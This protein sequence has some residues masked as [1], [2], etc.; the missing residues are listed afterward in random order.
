MFTGTHQGIQEEVLALKNIDRH[1]FEP[2]VAQIEA[3]KSSHFATFKDGL[4][5]LGQVVVGQVE[6]EPDEPDEG[7]ALE[8]G[9]R[10][11]A[12]VDLLKLG[13]VL[14]P[15]L[16]DLGHLVVAQTELSKLGQV[17]EVAVVDRLDQVR[18]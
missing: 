7:V 8:L 3:L 15:V 6:K 10:V 18:A 5:H 17:G 9:D 11:E 4:G 1:G 12:E 13:R 16:A 2:V 14:E